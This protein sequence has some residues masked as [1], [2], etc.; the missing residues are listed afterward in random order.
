MQKVPDDKCSWCNGS[1][2]G[3]GLP[4]PDCEGTGYK[5][6]KAVEAYHEYLMDI[7]FEWHEHLMNILVESF[8]YPEKRFI[9]KE[10]ETFVMNYF[11]NEEKAPPPKEEVRQFMLEELESDFFENFRPFG[12]ARIMQ[13]KQ[14]FVYLSLQEPPESLPVRKNGM[15]AY[16][17]ADYDFCVPVRDSEAFLAHI[18][19]EKVADDV[20]RF[21]KKV[22]DSFP[23]ELELTTS[24]QMFF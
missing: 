20:I 7:V 23:K 1:G 15:D 4:C 3:Y 18:G 11:A 9:P 19:G 13:T 14:V 10:T 5:Y 24:G 21:H 2:T 22:W 8:G 17:F 12:Y 6:G 16:M